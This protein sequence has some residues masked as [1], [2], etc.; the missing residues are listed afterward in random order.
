MVNRFGYRPVM[1]VGLVMVGLALLGIAYLRLHSPVWW[2]ILC[3]F[4]GLGMGMVVAPALH[5][6]AERAAAGAR[7][8]WVGGAETR[9][10]R[11]SVPASL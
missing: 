1:S 3:L 7:R 2:M 5:R 9:F 8:C 10:G 4:F 11:C 6:D